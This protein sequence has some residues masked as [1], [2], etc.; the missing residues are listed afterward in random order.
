MTE[1]SRIKNGFS[2]SIFGG[3][4]PERV[5]DLLSYKKTCCLVSVFVKNQ[6]TLQQVNVTA[7]YGLAA[8]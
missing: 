3:H 7:S 2:I 8:L 1:M 5:G 6:D 4:L